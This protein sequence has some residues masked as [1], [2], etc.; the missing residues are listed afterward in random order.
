M[1]GD[2]LSALRKRIA[3]TRQLETVFTAMRGVA[4]AR[5]REAQRSLDG[6]RAYAGA[7]GETI[8]I[9]LALSP[10]EPAAR[11]APTKRIV[12]AFCSEQGFAGPFDERVLSAATGLGA[13]AAL[14]VVGQRGEASA[15]E[16]GLAVAW[17]TPMAA[18]A[19]DAP[20]VAERI[21]DALYDQVA[22]NQTT[23]V[24]VIHATPFSPANFGVVT[25]SLIPL[26]LARFPIAERGSPPILNLA[27]PLLL[28]LLA[29]EYV[30]AELCEATLLSFASE[31]AARM[32]AMTSA[33]SNVRKTLDELTARHR[34][35]RQEQITGEVVEISRTSGDFA[36]R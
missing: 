20:S 28:S 33:R 19:V 26:D 24:T 3:A 9:A 15:I 30:F 1:S 21:A 18:H 11:R 27:P 22:R 6:A 2:E 16:R 12:L 25:R 31:N 34:R 23:Q 32:Q 17:S 4:A 8:R 7:V 29:E 14:Y 35:A 10:D 36:G 5:S 13:D